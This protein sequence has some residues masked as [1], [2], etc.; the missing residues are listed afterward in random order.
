MELTPHY[1]EMIQ[2]T[3]YK[4]SSQ[5]LRVLA[6]AGKEELGELDNYRGL[7]DTRYRYSVCLETLRA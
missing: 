6:F 4:W 3:L 7:H 2:K 5:S 1:R